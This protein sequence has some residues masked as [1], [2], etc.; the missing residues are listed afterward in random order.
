MGDAPAVEREWILG[1]LPDEARIRCHYRRRANR[2]LEYT[3]QLEIRHDEAW[4]PVIR[5]D[6]AHGFCHRDTIHP[7]GTQDKMPIHRGDSNDN[8]TWAIEELRAHWESE[9]TRF[10]REV[11][12]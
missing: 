9:R 3:V 1:V 5:Y 6:N 8:F 12:P 11:K 2:V 10:L 4:R 7:D